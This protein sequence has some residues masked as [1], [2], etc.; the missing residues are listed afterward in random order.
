MMLGF[1][2]PKE[3]PFGAPPDPRYLYLGASHSVALASLQYGVAADRGFTVLI[4]GPAMGK[5]T[6]VF[7]FL[8]KACQWAKTT[9]LSQ[10]HSTPQDMLRS[11]LE[12]SGIHDDA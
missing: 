11:L 1:Y 9:F 5:A 10:A 3:Q 2:K 12:D 8:S 7:D 4:A 6:S